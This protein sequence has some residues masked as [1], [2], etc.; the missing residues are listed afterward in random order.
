[1]TPG[2]G[3]GYD[4]I[5]EAL[6]SPRYLSL[7]QIKVV[8]IDH[9]MT[10][11]IL[12]HI[13]FLAQLFQRMSTVKNVNLKSQSKLTLHIDVFVEEANVEGFVVEAETLLNHKSSLFL[14]EDA[15]CPRVN[16]VCHELLAEHHGG[17]EVP[18]LIVL[19]VLLQERGQVRGQA[20]R[21]LFRGRGQHKAE[22]GHPAQPQE[23]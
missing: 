16:K 2:Q 8:K 11:A 5:L 13:F 23:V 10:Q 7:G 4:D 22:A 18:D 1:M 14:T 21:R 15:E 9:K 12:G 20:V 17:K 3:H 19:G 6:Y